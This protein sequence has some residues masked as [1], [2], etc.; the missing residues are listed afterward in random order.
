[1]LPLGA[2][3]VAVVVDIGLV[4][5]PHLDDGGVFPVVRS[6]LIVDPRE[7]VEVVVPTVV[8]DLDIFGWGRP[9]ELP[10]GFDPSSSLEGS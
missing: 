3:Y 8:A 9:D 10:I 6:G 1:M 5:T 2:T 7:P 4:L